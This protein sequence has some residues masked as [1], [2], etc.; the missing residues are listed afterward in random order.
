MY[1]PWEAGCYEQVIE[2]AKEAASAHTT[3]GDQT[4]PHNTSCLSGPLDST[5]A[6]GRERKACP[7]NRSMELLRLET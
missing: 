7:E 4:S 1:C 3:R 6:V 2:V 5:F